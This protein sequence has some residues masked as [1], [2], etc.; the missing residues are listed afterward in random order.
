MTNLAIFCHLGNY[1]LWPYLKFYINNVLA[2]GFPTDI[3]VSYQTN[4]PI[5]NQIIT[6]Y[7]NVILIHSLLG[8]DIGGQLLMTHYAFI[9]QKKYDYVLKIHT[10]TNSIWRR[11]LLDPIANSKELVT[12][13]IN[14]FNNNPTIG[15][16]AA[17]KWKLKLDALNHPLLSNICQ[18][19]KLSYDPSHSFIGGTI[20]WFRWDIMLSFININ[21]INLLYEYNLLEPGYHIN[22]H[23]TFTHSWERIFS[24]I[25]QHFNYTIYGVIMPSTITLLPP[26]F[27]WQFY[28]ICHPQ[29]AKQNY[30]ESTA[31]DHWI[32]YGRFHSSPYRLKD[33]GLSSFNW[34]SYLSRYPDLVSSGINN[35]D[36]AIKHFAIYGRLEGRICT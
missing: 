14:I 35:Y 12:D 32:D 18:R 2:T 16:I 34:S 24:I 1:K 23:P 25:I 10:K 36:Q 21:N 5:L 13:I 31:L 26:D 29:L 4:S 20:Y 15:L 8:C 3:Y 28:L 7:P 30:S 33:I 6:M 9:N 11:E 17:L 22:D 27:N 19:L